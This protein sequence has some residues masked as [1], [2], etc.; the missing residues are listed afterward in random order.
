MT[1]VDRNREAIVGT[2]ALEDSARADFARLRG[3]RRRRL[4]AAM[5]SEG[6]DALVLGRPANVRYAS[7]ARQLWRA[8]NAPFGPASVVVRATERV[9]LLSV[10]DEGV[11]PEID[12][13]DLY[14][15][16]WNPAHLLAALKAIDGLA[17]AR[18]VGTDGLT[19]MFAQQIHDVAPAA[20]IA[21]ATAVL[22]L[23]RATK[24]SDELACLRTA[25]A[26]A[27]A[28]LQVMRERVEPGVSERGL[29]AAYYECIGTLGVPAPPSESVA[30]ATPGRGPVDVRFIARDRPVGDGELVVLCP[31]ALYAGY[32]ADV[33]T[34]VL[35]GATPPPGAGQLGERCR[36]GLDALLDA[37]R[38]GATGGDL[39]GAW[40]RAGEPVPPVV[41]AHGLGLGAEPPVIGLGRGHSARL[42][43]GSVVCVQSW[44]SAEGTGGCLERATVHVATDG[45]ELLTRRAPFG[46]QA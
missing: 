13:E 38:P 21:D 41:L 42:E 7:G 19:P 36:R 39:Y 45:P 43:E 28:A 23:A 17:D 30:F 44:V 2:M 46:F 27:E 29:L 4:L 14:P 32:E 1:P 33:G 9:H 34:T 15:L 22:W 25:A 6:M 12:H 11:P 20:E 18:R 16:T 26:L 10:W 35:A 24:T 3:E 37:C 8:G 40:Q 31:G 5:A